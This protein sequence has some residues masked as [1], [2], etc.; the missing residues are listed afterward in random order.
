MTQTELA[1]A[2]GVSLRTIQHWEKGTKT[3]RADKLSVLARF[4]GVTMQDVMYE[5]SHKD[6]ADTKSSHNDLSLYADEATLLNPM[7]VMQ[8]PLIDKLAQAGYGKGGGWDDDQYLNEL[9][10]MPVFVSHEHKGTYRCYEISGYSMFDETFRSYIPGD[11]ILCRRIEKHLWQHKF[12][13][14]SNVFLINEIHRGL[15]LKEIKE[16]KVDEGQILCH[17]WNPEYE[18]YWIDL[19]DC[20]EIYNVIK[21]VERNARI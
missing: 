17:S 4:F 2:I 13:I 8:V 18:D 1:D 3:P 6:R 5:S 20:H 14:R 16:H 7:Q 19:N 15:V 10:K 11:I 21:I 9:S 12:H